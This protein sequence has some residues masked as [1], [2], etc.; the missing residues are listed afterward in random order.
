[1]TQAAP[2]AAGVPSVPASRMA[3]T[4][5]TIPGM[6]IGQ[7]VIMPAFS[8]AQPRKAA[9][10]LTVRPLTAMVV[11][12]MRPATVPPRAAAVGHSRAG[13]LPSAADGV[14]SRYVP[15]VIAALMVMAVSSIAA[16]LPLPRGIV[17]IAAMPIA[18][19]ETAAGDLIIPV[20]PARPMKAAIRSPAGR[21]AAATTHRA[22]VSTAAVTVPA[23]SPA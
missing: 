8:A 9:E 21:M 16:A 22:V 1:M 23:N 11:T 4:A 15:P 2:P 19:M 14:T 5:A 13:S 17:P 6:P 20:T 3:P 10:G 18:A 12:M 7:P